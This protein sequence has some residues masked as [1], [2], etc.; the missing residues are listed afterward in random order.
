MYHE[1]LCPGFQPVGRIGL[2]A[3]GDVVVISIV[4]R[5]VVNGWSGTIDILVLLVSSPC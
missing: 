3:S 4:W 5:F 2:A 1:L